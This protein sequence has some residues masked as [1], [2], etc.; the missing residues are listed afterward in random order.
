MPDFIKIVRQYLCL[1][2][3]HKYK[4]KLIRVRARLH[5]SENCKHMPH[6]MET[7]WKLFFKCCRCE[8]KATL[9]KWHL[10]GLNDTSSDFDYD[11]DATVRGVVWYVGE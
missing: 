3:Y 7:K 6:K 11:G 5:P 10:K 2:H 1:H 4:E 9:Y 8:H